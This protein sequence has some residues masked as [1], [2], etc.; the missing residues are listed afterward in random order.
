MSDVL[1][2]CVF[3]LPAPLSIA[4]CFI[5]D[6]NKIRGI[7]LNILLLANALLYVSPLLYAYLATPSGGNMWSENGPGAALW[8]YF[9]ILPIC[10]LAFLVLLILKL[11]FRKKS[12]N[13]A[14]NAT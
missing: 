8:L 14:P 11:V 10:G 2:L 3:I 7:V 6:S 13:K 4:L 12:V 9:I 1:M 5:K